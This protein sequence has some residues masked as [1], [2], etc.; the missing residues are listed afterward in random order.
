MGMNVVSI[1]EKTF[2]FLAT[3]STVGKQGMGALGNLSV[4]GDLQLIGYA[5]WLRH[6]A[7]VSTVGY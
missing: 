7:T 3:V 1:K 6:L 2:A 4:G 5:D